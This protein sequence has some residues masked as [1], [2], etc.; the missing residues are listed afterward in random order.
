MQAHLLGRAILPFHNER[1]DRRIPYRHPLENIG[2][3]STVFE[4]DRPAFWG[5]MAFTLCRPVA[6]TIDLGGGLVG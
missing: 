6:I 2:C 1:W 5:N 4:N 3:M